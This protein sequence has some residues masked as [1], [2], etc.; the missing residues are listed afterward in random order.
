MPNEPMSDIDKLENNF[1]LRIPAATK[2]MLDDL[3][4]VQK[5]KLNEAILIT[6]AK[7]IHDSK[8]DA[9]LYLRENAE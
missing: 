6:I 2:R 3:S 8:F 1:S 7:A 4:K 9:R 5:T